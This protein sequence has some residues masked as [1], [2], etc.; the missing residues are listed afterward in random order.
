MTSESAPQKKSPDHLIGQTL[1]ARYLIEEKLGEGTLAGRCAL[2]PRP[3][4]W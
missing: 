1:A 3:S 2:R 4:R